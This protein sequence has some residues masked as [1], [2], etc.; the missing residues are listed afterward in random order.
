MAHLIERHVH[1][2]NSDQQTNIPFIEAIQKAVHTGAPIRFRAALR[3]PRRSAQACDTH[4]RETLFG[5]GRDKMRSR[6]LGALNNVFEHARS[7][8]NVGHHPSEPR[9]FVAEIG[10]KRR[11]ATSSRTDKERAEIRR[12]LLES[13]EDIREHLFTTSEVSRYFPKFWGKRIERRLLDVR[14]LVR[15]ETLLAIQPTW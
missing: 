10:E 4:A 14:S 7:C 3:V 1:F 6:L 9:C 13:A 8:R 15:H 12:L 5:R 2:I 11:F